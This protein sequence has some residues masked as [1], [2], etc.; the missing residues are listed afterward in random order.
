MMNKTEIL[1]NQI[2]QSKIKF[3]LGNQIILDDPNFPYWYRN[4]AWLFRLRW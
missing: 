4:E 1:F 2:A 3:E